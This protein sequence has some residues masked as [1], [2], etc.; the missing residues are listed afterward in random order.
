MAKIICFANQK[1]G[2]GKTTSALLF[3][4]ALAIKGY[5][6]L[7]V[8]CDAQGN[9]TTCCGYHINK[10]RQLIESQSL[11][12]RVVAQLNHSSIPTENVLH[13]QFK[14][15]A[16]IPEGCSFDLIPSEI[17]LAGLNTVLAAVMSR[18]YI[19]RRVLE[20][21]RDLYDYIIIDCLP[22]LGLIS[23]NAL[24]AADEVIIPVQTQYFAVSGL[25][26]LFGTINDIRNNT[27]PSLVVKGILLTITNMRTNIY[28]RICAEL[29][30][31]LD[32]HL[33]VFKTE[34]PSTILIT[35]TQSQNRT[36]FETNND[37]PV[38]VAYYN[39]T[40]EYLNG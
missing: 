7:L 30:E 23:I 16:A 1:G 6:V 39:F 18:E 17:S 15:N 8:D 22:E 25:A 35:T 12:S 38:S 21:F 37:A 19:I 29:H 32:A 28:K 9:L 2:V 27:N 10:H 11:Y 24:T 14:P 40:E 4:A 20:P 31:Q 3:G 13:Y 26:Q 5:K 33:T 34:I 36:V